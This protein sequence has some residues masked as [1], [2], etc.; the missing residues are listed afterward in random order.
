MASKAACTT[1]GGGIGA[2]GV[3]DVASCAG[4]RCSNVVSCFKAQRGMGFGRI[5]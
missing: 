4:V 1:H 2:R 5:A 3:D